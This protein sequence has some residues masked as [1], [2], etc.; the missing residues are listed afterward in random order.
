[1]NMDKYYVTIR[2]QDKL[3]TSTITGLMQQRSLN[4]GE[5]SSMSLS[6]SLD[7]PSVQVWR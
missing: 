6:F 3:A 7:N 4:H 2:L 5:V 1:M